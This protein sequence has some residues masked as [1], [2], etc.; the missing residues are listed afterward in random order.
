MHKKIAAVFLTAV[1]AFC[2]TAC[3]VLPVEETSEPTATTAP[4]SSQL[5][6]EDNSIFGFLP[7]QGGVS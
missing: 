6:E 7:I 3:S 5:P 1:L 4:V 2:L